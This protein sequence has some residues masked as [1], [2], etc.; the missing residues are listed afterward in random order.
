MR[1]GGRKRTIRLPSVKRPKMSVKELISRYGLQALFIAL[2][3]LGLAVGAACSRS[4]DSEL[5]ERLDILFVTN[6]EARLEMS[7]FGIFCSCFV[8]YFLFIF[9]LFLFS[10]SAWGFVS[11]PVLS[12][13]KGFSVGLSSAFIFAAYRLSGIGFFIL[14]VLPGAAM[15][16]FALVR[17]SCVCFRLSLRYARLTVFGIDGSQAL[18]AEL[19]RFLRDSLFA[20]VFSAFC[21]VADMLMWIMFA[22]KFHF[23]Q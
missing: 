10:L 7:A 13:F 1:L 23:S 11:A 4:F 15:F 20:F 18:R 14:I 19:K 17:Y 22:D 21:A 5:F 2:F 12:V 16:L 6:I 3:L 9:L 8:S